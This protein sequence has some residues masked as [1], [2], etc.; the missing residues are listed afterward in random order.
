MSTVPQQRSE[1]SIRPLTARKAFEQLSLSQKLYAHHLSKACWLGTKIIRAQVS[2]ESPSICEFILELF[3]CC[4]GDWS[5][6]IDGEG[7]PGQDANL[8]AF[9]N[10]AALALF[11]QGNYYGYGDKKFLPGVPRKFLQSMAQK[12]SEKAVE[13]FRQCVELMLSSEPNGL[14]FTEKGGLSAYYVGPEA[15]TKSEVDAID[16]FLDERGIGQENTRI[17]KSKEDEHAR[18]RVL[19]ACVETEL[20]KTLGNLNSG[21]EDA[22]EHADNGEQKEFLAEYIRYFESGDVSRFKKAQSIWLKDRSPVVESIIGFVE[23]YR[24][25]AGRRAEFEGIVALTDEEASKNLVKLVE[26]SKEVILDMPWVRFFEGRQGMGPFESDR[27]EA[28][29]F[30]AIHALTYC[31][32]VIYTGINL[33]N[34]SDIRDHEGFKNVMIANRNYPPDLSQVDP[35]KEEPFVDP[36]QAAFYLKTYHY[37]Q[38]LHIALHELIGHGTGNKLVKESDEGFDCNNLPLSPITKEPVNSFYKL[39]E[40]VNSVFGKLA[41]TLAEC[42]ADCVGL[43]LIT[44]PKILEIFG[45]TDDSDMT[46]EDIIHACYLRAA[47]NGVTALSK[48]DPKTNAWGEAHERGFFAILN[49]MLTQEGFVTL[50]KDLEAKKLKVS[51]DAS[52]IITHGRKAVEAF[53]LEL[54]MWRCTGDLQSAT[55]RYEKLTSV[56]DEWIQIR[57]TVV[58]QPS[59]P[60]AYIQGN[61][62]IKGDNDV[63]LRE[64]EQS[65]AGVIQSWAERFPRC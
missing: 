1:V 57:D 60:W 6:L 48:F 59:K 58:A 14:G 61:T 63:E 55:D 65:P 15:I 33:P 41:T 30:T 35:V 23:E 20:P 3:H 19:Q 17:H 56:N 28:P 52:K 12:A 31:S 39:G 51:L 18:Y 7:F 32:T 45:Y 2:A 9:L 29:E 62:F 40:T 44:N 25:P 36:S 13:L 4:K 46:A 10:Y 50:E 38:Y 21:E 53:L 11:N 22:R 8:E 16:K 42:R 27:F 64:Y 54:H 47:I 43:C 34:Y 37:S 24:D 5:K 26:L 49:I